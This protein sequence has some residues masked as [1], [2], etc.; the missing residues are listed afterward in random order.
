MS[1]RAWIGLRRLEACGADDCGGDSPGEAEGQSSELILS[2]VR[3]LLAS[4]QVR[5]AILSGS[6]IEQLLA[7]IAPHSGA[8]VAYTL[9]SAPGH[10]I[11]GTSSLAGC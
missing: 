9:T 7:S 5:P 1:Q 11:I 3:G 2:V 6:H 8:D 4:F 10:C